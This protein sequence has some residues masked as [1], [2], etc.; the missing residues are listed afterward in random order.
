[1]NMLSRFLL[2]ALITL[3]LTA[4]TAHAQ[5]NCTDIPAYTMPGSI[6]GSWSYS[7]RSCATGSTSAFV[8]MT[9]SYDNYSDEIGSSINGS[10]GF[11]SSTDTSNTYI[12]SYVINGGPL[13]FM[14]DAVEIY[15]DQLSYSL[16]IDPTTFQTR[17]LNISGGMR[18]NGIYYPATS[19]LGYVGTGGAPNLDL[20]ALKDLASPPADTS[21]TPFNFTGV[22]EVAPGQVVESGLITVSGI[23]AST[24]ISIVGGEYSVNGGSWSSAAGTVSLGNQIRIR[25][26]APSGYGETA[27]A[28]LTIGDI[29]AG[30]SVGTRSFVAVTAPTEI[31]ANPQTATVDSSG[32]VRLSAAPT[33]ALQ[34]AAG[35][36][37]NAVIALDTA[38]AIPVASGTATLSYT[39]NESDTTLQIREVNGVRALV[40]IAGSVGIQAPAAG[41]TIPVA[42]DNNGSAS[43]ETAAANTQ[44]IAGRDTGRNVVVAITSGQVRYTGPSR[45][46]ALPTSFD[47]YSGEAVLADES[48]A[49][50]QV[51]LGSFAQDGSQT[52]DFIANLPRAAS[53][54]KVPRV[55]GSSQRFGQDWTLLVGQAIATK[56]GLGTASSLSQDAAGVMT[57][58]TSSG[59]YRFLPVGSLA[60]AD[61]AVRAVSVADIAANLTA[62]LDTSLSFAVAPATAYADLETALKRTLGAS[63]SL[64][65]LGDGVLMASYNGTDYIAQPASQTTLGPATACPGFVTE[66]N[67]LALCDAAG[68]RQVLSAAFANTDALRDTFRSALSLPSLSVSNDNGAYSANVGGTPYSLSPDITLTSPPSTEA[69]KLWWIDSSTNKIFIRYPSGMAQGFGLE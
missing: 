34:L 38:A 64:E 32:I 45:G 6:S 3:L 26:T 15:Y 19:M 35:A 17:Y 36:T 18:V 11:T 33:A 37:L 8:S 51:R 59:T 68:K 30:F 39:R 5:S 9:F 2:V 53:T 22:S 44:V 55:S 61:P 13:L 23:D 25:L 41:S 14:P 58:V 66:N 31:F 16:Q 69:G 1:M 46:R 57:L 4:R 49:A 63:A 21:P 54:L 47:V 48:G 50:G 10:Y 29:S 42:G 24:P 67:Q 62:I 56:L 7:M 12:T 20:D 65:I 28:T 40:P 27:S 60:L 43:L 52:G